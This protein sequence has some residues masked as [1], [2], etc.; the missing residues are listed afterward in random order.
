MFTAAHAATARNKI[1]KQEWLVVAKVEENRVAD[2]MNVKL[3]GN[4]ARR[5]RGKVTRVTAR[6]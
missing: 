2:N 4:R 1:G 3:R 5:D 6:S